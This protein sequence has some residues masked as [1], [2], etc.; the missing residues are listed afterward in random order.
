MTLRQSCS[1]ARREREGISLPNSRLGIRALLIAFVLALL[2]FNHLSFAAESTPGRNVL[3]LYGFSDRNIYESIEKLKSEV[4]SRV[5]VPVNF[6]VEYLESQHLDDTGYET[7][8]STTLQHAYQGKKVD[9]VLAASYPALRFAVTHRDQ[10]FPGAPIVF[11]YLAPNRFDSQNKIDGQKLWPGVTGVTE[12]ID[13]HGTLDLALRLQPDTKNVAVVTGTSSEFERYWL[14]AFHD[15]LRPYEDRL[16]LIDL[17]GLPTELLL[18]RVA[19]LPAHT[20]IFFQLEAHSSSQPLLGVYDVLA[21]ISQRFPTYSVFQRFLSKGVIGGSYADYAE[22]RVKSGELVARILSG[23][24]AGDIPVIHDSGAHT[25]VDWRQLRRWNIPE[26]ALPAGS[27]VLDR[28]PTAWERYKKF[29]LG[30]V[31]LVLLQVLLIIAL[32]WQRNRA[33]KVLRQSEA[34]LRTVADNSHIGLAMVDADRSHVYANSPYAERLGWNAFEIVGKLMPEVLPQEIQDQVSAWLNRAFAGEHVSYERTLPDSETGRDRFYAVT[35]EPL[36]TRDKVTRVIVTTVDITERKRA[37]EEVFETQQRLK[38]LVEALP[39]GVNFSDNVTCQRITGNPAALAQF[40]ARSGDNISASAPDDRAP[41]RQIK[42]F[43]EGRQVSDSELALQRAVAEN[44]AIPPFELEVQ[45]PSGRRW[46]M[47]TSGAPV[48]DQQGNV[49][50]GVAV[51]VDITE[52]KRAEDALWQSEQRFRLMGETA[53]FGVWMADAEGKIM[54]LSQILLDLIG[55]TMDEVRASGLKELLPQE[56]AQ[57]AVDRWRHCVRTG[58]D[59]ESE[60][61]IRGSDGV[62]RT[63]LSRGKPVRDLHG[64]IVAWA[65]VNLDISDRKR[66]EEALIRSEK[67]ASIG[68]MASTMAHEIN[69]PLAAAMN[70]VF[71]ARSSTG[72]PESACQYLDIADRELRR[73]EHIAQQALGFYSVSIAPTKISMT[74]LLDAIVDLLKTKIKSKRVILEKQYQDQPEVTAVAGELRQVFSTL[75]INSLDAVEEEGTIKLRVSNGQARNGGRCVRVTV[76]D[77]GKGINAATLPHIFEAFYTTKTSVGV[78]LSLWVGKQIIDKHG[79]FIRVRSRAIEGHRGT[80]F[81]VVLPSAAE[82]AAESPL[83]E[84][85]VASYSVNAQPTHRDATAQQNPAPEPRQGDRGA[86]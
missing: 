23:E 62:Y 26:S 61:R 86:A 71:L 24:K 3:V 70:T 18:Q 52:R 40:E 69:N 53:P 75:L 45:L 6:Y 30:T 32:L 78:G 2:L 1:T 19:D 83:R 43:R 14:R 44:R 47:E 38:A 57:P 39:V 22:Q 35:L 36:R 85:N 11:S 41:F 63:I 29:I 37:E 66:S 80:T 20:I 42:F 67:L 34:L 55:M 12:T 79:G 21:L 16:R 27:V 56:D 33:E 73:I 28:E 17:V 74:A 49:V 60:L 81:S 9:V 4:R 48:R 31:A 54:Y 7:S 8:L 13:F 72:L 50:G 76:A 68:R 15:E 77:N 59:W 51:T 10:I 65:G 46:L 25:Y 82:L 58:E 5:R 84:G 64:Q